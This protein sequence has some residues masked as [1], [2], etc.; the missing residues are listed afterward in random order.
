MNIRTLEACDVL[1]CGGGP[2][3]FCAAVAAARTGAKTALVEKFGMA[4][5]TLTVLGNNSIDMF[6]NPHR[7]EDRM[8]IQG[9]GWEFVR[10]LNAMGEAAV[11]D[12][13]AP[14]TSNQQYGI[15]VKPLSAAKLMDDM[16]LEAGVKLYYCQGAADVETAAEGD[17]TRVTGVLIST[18]AGL[19]R[20]PAKFVVDCTGD[21]DICTWAGNPFESGGEDGALQP[22][23][24]RYYLWG[25]AT[26]EEIQRGDE[27]LWNDRQEGR[28]TWE[29]L[30]YGANFG[31][32]LYS[33]GDNRNHVMDLN[34]ADSDSRTAAEIEA[35]RRLCLVSDAI[36]RIGTNVTIAGTA[37]EVAPRESRRIM[38]DK[39]LTAEDWIGC[40]MAPDAVCYTF[41]H[42]DIHAKGQYQKNHVYLNG[43]ETP[44]IPLGCL[45]P[46][47]LTN[48][49][50][51]GRCISGD[52]AA[53]SATRVKATCMATGEAAGTAAALAAQ[54]NSADVREAT[55]DEVR[56]ALAK[57]GAIVP[58][59]NEPVK[60]AL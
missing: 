49:M 43:P 54:K 8:V 47:T 57:A 9:I 7:G 55:A 30:L 24:L 1:V 10:R 34:S 37:P 19:A 20:I 38:G 4:G 42:I 6:V 13:N 59:L 50:V 46:K 16:L 40:R 21:G 18:K 12:M 11:P 32:I 25:S 52:R 22:G 2:A 3:G 44:S 15:R 14:F 26:R 41:W 60:F 31:A 53:V 56:A 33:N 36:K 5:G 58:G 35:R 29:D 23:T 48:V 45:T 27:M 39:L 28:L 51:A 17:R